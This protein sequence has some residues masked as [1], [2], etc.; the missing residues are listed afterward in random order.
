MKNK[1]KGMFLTLLMLFATLYPSG[2]A[3]ANGLPL[4]GISSI[5]KQAI[6]NELVNNKDYISMMKNCS[7]IPM[8]QL[9][10]MSISNEEQIKDLNI[11]IDKLK[12]Q[13]KFD[14]DEYAKMLGFNGSNQIIEIYRSANNDFKK[15]VQQIPE[16]K[17]INESDL[18]DIYKLTFK[19]NTFV[20]NLLNECKQNQRLWAVQCFLHFANNIG[21]VFTVENYPAI[22]AFIWCSI[23]TVI[24]AVSGAILTADQ[25]MGGVFIAISGCATFAFINGVDITGV[26]YQNAKNLFDRCLNDGFYN[27]PNTT[28][29]GVVNQATAAMANI[30]TAYNALEEGKQD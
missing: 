1:I 26:R 22:G 29:A 11:K 13:N 2:Q 5:Q 20:E 16:I 24:T 17:S 27:N 3:Y 25:I 19:N 28:V 9:A 7:I 15:I 23:G 6:S 18:Q 4:T 30:R 12:S 14:Q 10:R 8:L 21:V